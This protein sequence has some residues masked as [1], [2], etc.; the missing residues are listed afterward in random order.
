VCEQDWRN[1][2][3][4]AYTLVLEPFQLGGLLKSTWRFV[5]A[6]LSRLWSLQLESPVGGSSLEARLYDVFLQ[7][8]ILML[9]LALLIDEF[10]DKK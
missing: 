3:K 5:V 9:C 6:I 10:D 1:Q 2:A 7:E 8:G 4:S